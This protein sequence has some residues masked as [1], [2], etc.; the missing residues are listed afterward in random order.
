MVEYIIIGTLIILKL[1]NNC[2][3]NKKP[4]FNFEGDNF[5]LSILHLKY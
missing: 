1:E 4:G 3:G 2:V 5:T